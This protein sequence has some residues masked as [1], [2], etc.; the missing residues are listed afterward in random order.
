[1][2][3]DRMTDKILHNPPTQIDLVFAIKKIFAKNNF[4]PE[5]Q[6][7]FQANQDPINKQFEAERSNRLVITNEL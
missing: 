4:L 2:T 5:K 1:M 3:A 7:M 6:K